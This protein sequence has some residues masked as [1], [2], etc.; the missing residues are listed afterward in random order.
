MNDTTKQ[1]SMQA[2]FPEPGQYTIQFSIEQKVNPTALGILPRQTS[3]AQASIVWS[4]EGGTIQ[5]RV[6]V[7]NGMSISGVGEA[8]KIVMTDTTRAGPSFPAGFDPDYLVA[9]QVSRGVRANIQQPPTLLPD[10]T[11]GAGNIWDDGFCELPPLGVSHLAIIPQ[12]AGVVSVSV[13][14]CSPG[15]ALIPEG[16][17]FVRQR[18]SATIGRTFKEYDPRDATWVPL[19][20]G[21]NAI[22]VVNTNAF[23]VDVSMLYGIDG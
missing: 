15:G 10:D 16:S 5:R 19:A 22:I 11:T 23:N 14:V 8:V 13:Q 3:Q 9:C 21:A 4:V 20:P 12:N 1:V 2:D 18:T 6:E 17:V 7:A